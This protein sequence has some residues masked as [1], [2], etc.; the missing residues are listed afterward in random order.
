MASTGL[1]LADASATRHLLAISFTPDDP[2]S[3][4]VIL[5]FAGGGAVRLSVECLEAELRDLGPR[6]AVEGRPPERLDAGP[7]AAV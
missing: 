7:A 2:P 6:W 4:H 1:D 3:G 5:A